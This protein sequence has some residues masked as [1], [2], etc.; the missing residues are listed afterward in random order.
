MTSTNKQSLFLPNEALSMK[1]GCNNKRP[2]G[3][4]DNGLEQTLHVARR[5]S[6][7]Q[8]TGREERGTGSLGTFYGGRCKGK[9]L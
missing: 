9:K 4:L 8:D 6:D 2:P 7:G 3:P 5:G 1:M